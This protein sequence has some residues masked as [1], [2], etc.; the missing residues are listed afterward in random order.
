L[1]L[2]RL[3]FGLGRRLPSGAQLLDLSL[4]LQ[5]SVVVFV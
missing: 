2:L 4:H 5:G 1:W 3:L